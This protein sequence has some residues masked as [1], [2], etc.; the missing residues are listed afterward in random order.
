MEP[1]I[2]VRLAPNGAN[3]ITE[4]RPPKRAPQLRWCLLWITDEVSANHGTGTIFDR[5]ISGIVGLT[6]NRRFSI[7]RFACI[8]LGKGGILWIH[9]CSDRA[10]S[11][12]L[13]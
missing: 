2:A 9:R 12:F 11:I 5:L 4:G 3:R 13:L 10:S 8:E 7:I 6:E 1:R